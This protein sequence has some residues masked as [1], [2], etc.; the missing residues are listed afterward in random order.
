MAFLPPVEVRRAEVENFLLVLDR[1][2]RHHAIE[3]GFTRGGAKQLVV[4]RLQLSVSERIRGVVVVLQDVFPDVHTPEIPMADG[5]FHRSVSADLLVKV[6]FVLC[7]I[8]LAAP[9]LLLFRPSIEEA[10]SLVRIHRQA[11]IDGWGF[12]RQ[13]PAACSAEDTLWRVCDGERARH[14]NPAFR[15][16]DVDGRA[17]RAVHAEVSAKKDFAAPLEVALQRRSR[18]I[19]VV[20]LELLDCAF[21]VAHVRVVFAQDLQPSS[22]RGHVVE[23]ERE[24]RFVQLPRGIVTRSSELDQRL[25]H[26]PFGHDVRRRQLG[27]L[28]LL[29][30]MLAVRALD[31]ELFDDATQDA[32]GLEDAGAFDEGL[33]ARPAAGEDPVT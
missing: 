2:P 6:S 28:C 33:S 11:I 22:Q 26:H 9:S 29:G 5:A 24:H 17:L 13:Q 15:A 27:A 30:V 7:A 19:H 32:L 10:C 25:S 16:L 23:A 1:L 14:D 20:P 3:D 4:L 8:P 18:A 31:M 12:L 21:E